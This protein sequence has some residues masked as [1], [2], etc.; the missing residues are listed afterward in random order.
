MTILV[1][2]SHSVCREFKRQILSS[3]FLVWNSIKETL[4]NVLKLIIEELG[5][6]FYGNFE[7]MLKIILNFCLSEYNCLIQRSK[8][9]IGSDI[10]TTKIADFKNISS[11]SSTQHNLIM[12]IFHFSSFF[13][14][15]LT[16]CFISMTLSQKL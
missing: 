10:N 13:Y 7:I 5:K 9:W 3:L 1:I 12:Q 8:P 14:Y 4:Q 11:S 2:F 16:H 6:W 15:S